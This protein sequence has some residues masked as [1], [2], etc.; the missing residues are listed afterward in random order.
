VTPSLS[1]LQ[2]RHWGLLTAA[3]ALAAAAGR[4]GVGGVL[5]GGATIGL[6]V[7]L[8]S[9]GLGAVL[10]RRRPRLAIGILFVKLLALLGLTWMVFVARQ[11]RPDPL[12]FALGVTCLPVA[13]AWEAFRTRVKD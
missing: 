9:V 4:P 8:Y 13:A 2:L 6:S 1:R 10:R 3:V 12:G 5:L 11:H 7:L